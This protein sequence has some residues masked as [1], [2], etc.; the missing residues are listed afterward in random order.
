MWCLLIYIFFYLLHD[1][2]VHGDCIV[3]AEYAKCMNKLR[4]NEKYRNLR[5]P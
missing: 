3:C 5:V 4:T 1:E 2:R